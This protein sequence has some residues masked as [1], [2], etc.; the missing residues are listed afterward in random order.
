VP[1]IDIREQI[2]RYKKSSDFERGRENEQAVIETYQ[3]VFRP[4]NLDNLTAEEFRSF[5]LIKNNRHWDGIHRYGGRLT[6]DMDHLRAALRLLV[7]E[8]RT[9]E[10]RLN[11][12]FPKGGENFI[13]GLGRATVTPIL[14]VTYPDKY[15]VYNRR[16]QVALEALGLHPAEPGLSFAEKYS[17]INEDLSSLAEDHAISFFMLDYLLGDIASQ[18]EKGVRSSDQE[19]EDEI[20]L[21]PESA[22]RDLLVA[23]WGTIEALCEYEIYEEDGEQA[24]EYSTG[25]VGRIDILARHPDSRDWVVLE[26]KKGAGSDRVVGQVLRYKGWVRQNLAKGD[27]Q[28]RG[29]I[30]ADEVDEKLRYA[31]SE[32]HDVDVLLYDIDITLNKPDWQ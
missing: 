4:D 32:I 17:K 31:I 10:E 30:I 2:K 21:V 1:D 8:E 14:L 3:P 5:L 20:L 27:Q 29:L 26:L 15:G 24:V 22:L 6:E 9:I 12:L 18:V 7:D 28:V 23:Q 13:K 16:V 25:K 11:E 19:F